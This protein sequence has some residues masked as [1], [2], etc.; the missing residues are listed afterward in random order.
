MNNLAASNRKPTWRD[1]VFPLVVGV[2]S[3]T[4]VIRRPR[5]ASIHTVDVLE[6]VA[7]GIMFGLALRAFAVWIHAWLR[8]R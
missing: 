2:F 5:F 4:V 8:T 1:I 3:L 6:L 7:A